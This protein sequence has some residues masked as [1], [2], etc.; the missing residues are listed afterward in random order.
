MFG[1]HEEKQASVNEL[2]PPEG[3][4]PHEHQDPVQ[5][6]HGDELEDGGELDREPSEEEHTDAGDPLLPDQWELV[7]ESSDQSK[8]NIQ[9][10]YRVSQKKNAH[11]IKIFNLNPF[12]FA[13]ICSN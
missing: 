9:Y 2:H 5:D 6:R 1:R 4:D 3:V 11:Q 8:K 12:F 13:P 10:M 7:L